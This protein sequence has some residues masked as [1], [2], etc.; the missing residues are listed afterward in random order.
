MV[1]KPKTPYKL[2][3]NY[4]LL[5]LLI[6]EGYQIPCWIDYD[7]DRKGDIVRD[8]CCARRRKE[9]SISISARGMGY[10]SVDSFE[11]EWTKLSEKELFIQRCEKMNIE[12][13]EPTQQSESITI[14][15]VV[16]STNSQ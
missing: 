7:W 9:W 2:S 1:E 13:I 16:D 12:F 11:Q 15:E 6:S 5:F 8:L 14:V 4:E 3:K 10:L